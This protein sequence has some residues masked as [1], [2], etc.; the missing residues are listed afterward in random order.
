MGQGMLYEELSMN[1]VFLYMLMYLGYAKAVL[2]A[3]FQ[4]I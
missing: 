4:D 2:A 3:S 1:K